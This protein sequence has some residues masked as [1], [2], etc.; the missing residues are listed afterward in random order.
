MLELSKLS[1]TISLPILF[2]IS[3]SR[4]DHILSKVKP[5]SQELA[6]ADNDSNIGDVMIRD[7]QLLDAQATVVQDPIT[8]G[9]RMI[10]S[11]KCGSKFV[12]MI[13]K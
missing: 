9:Q 12:T 13:C 8:N 1:A 2:A 11:S 4:G 7:M 3:A 10:V 5:L 6:H